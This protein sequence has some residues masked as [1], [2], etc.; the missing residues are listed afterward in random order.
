M[1]YPHRYTYERQEEMI[2]V[3]HIQQA[4]KR[5]AQQAFDEAR[6]EA[7]QRGRKE[8]AQEILEYVVARQSRLAQISF[9][10]GRTEIHERKLELEI[11]E[12]KIKEAFG[13]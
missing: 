2:T 1:T 6:S 9:A 3:E 10:T 4:E 11:L 13:V 7:S 5:L 12:R 8:A